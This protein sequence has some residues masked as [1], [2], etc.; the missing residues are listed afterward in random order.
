MNAR[1]VLLLASVL[2]LT[3]CD[4]QR[5]DQFAQ[6]AAAGNVYVQ[7][8]HKLI[9]EA[10]S[11]FIAADSITTATTRKGFTAANKA[12]VS[13]SIQDQDKELADYLGNLDLLD[14]H[15]TVLGNLF[16]AIAKLA[17]PKQATAVSTSATGLLTSLDSLDGNISKVKF[18]GGTVS[19]VVGA[20]AGLIA[21][22]FQVAALKGRFD[23]AIPTIDRA[24][25]LQEAALLSISA[26]IKASLG[27]SL[28]VREK[29]QILDPFTNF[30][31]PLPATWNADREAFIRTKA[32][33]DDATRAS[34]AAKT[35]HQAFRDLVAGNSTVNAKAVADSL[36]NI[37][38][39]L[40]AIQTK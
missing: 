11:A 31:A 39:I 19:G 33:A 5:L 21:T 12:E 7:A 1:K 26:Q 30:A 6:F 8:F 17:D 35:L 3:G 36:K 9:P 37:T 14:R 32:V 29:Q 20:G 22:H 34:E 4:S 28:Q 18:P 27:V 24:L 16:D 23:K 13:K 38:D 25:S 10:G 2:L 15:A 40:T